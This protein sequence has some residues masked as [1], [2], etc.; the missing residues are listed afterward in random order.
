MWLPVLL[1]PQ[2]AYRK[3][4][5]ASIEFQTAAAAR[6]SRKSST[7]SEI[8]LYLLQLGTSEVSG[9]PIY[10]LVLHISFCDTTYYL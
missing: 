2:N 5:Y 8:S 10:S 4:L 7:I 3:Q 1:F 9:Y 6:H